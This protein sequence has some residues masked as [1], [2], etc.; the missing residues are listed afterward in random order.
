MAVN[1]IVFTDPAHITLN[2]PV[3]S[4]AGLG[5]RTA[6]V[7]NP[8]GQSAISA[9]G[10][11]TVT[12]SVDTDGDGSPDWWVQQHFGHP[13]GQAGDKSLAGRDADGDGMSNLDEYRAGTNPRSPAS[14]MRITAI[15]VDGAGAHITFGSLAGKNYR[16]EYKTNVTDG[17]WTLVATNIPG[18]NGTMTAHDPAAAGMGSSACMRH[19][20]D[21]PRGP[22]RA[23]QSRGADG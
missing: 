1:D 8:E 5:S 2:V 17:S 18:L 6:S 10:I 13:T 15:S 9:S 7:T 22:H 12:A 11:L 23:S 19:G 21:G 20:A 16:L 14:V 4:T 3:A